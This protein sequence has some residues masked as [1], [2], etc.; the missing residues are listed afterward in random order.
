LTAKRND[1]KLYNLLVTGLEEAWESNRYELPQSRFGEYTA[2]TI[3]IRYQSLDE[4]LIQELISFPAL[5]A[6]EVGCNLPARVGYVTQIIQSSET[7]RLKFKMIKEILP[8]S[9]EQLSQ[10]SWDLDIMKMEMNRTHWALKDVDLLAVLLEAGLLNVREV[11]HELTKPQIHFSIYSQNQ[12][13]VSPKV[14][15]IPRIEIDPNLIS[16]MMPFSREFDAVYASIQ[17]ACQSVGLRCERAD[18]LWEESTII[19][20]VFNLIFRSAVVVVDLSGRNSNVLYETGI[21]HTLGRPVVPISQNTGALP[22][23]LAHHRTLHYLPNEQGLGEMRMRLERR[24]RSL[25]R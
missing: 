4:H 3:K 14:F 22:F 21:A 15:A 19:Q 16:V 9:P 8:I 1:V 5:F 13:L 6:Y 23:D 17:S 7:I 25:M 2:E 18:D 20:D 11:P 24:L 12:L 10:I